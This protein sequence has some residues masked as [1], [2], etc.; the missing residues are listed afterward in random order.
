MWY[1]YYVSQV[2]LCIEGGSWSSCDALA[3]ELAAAGSLLLQQSVVPSQLHIPLCAT[4][5]SNKPW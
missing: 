1:C 2:L 3:T 5:R 4:L